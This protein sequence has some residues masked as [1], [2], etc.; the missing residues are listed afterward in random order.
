MF[1]VPVVQKFDVF[2][3]GPAQIHTSDKTLPLRVCGR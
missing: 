1:S 3:E 2:F